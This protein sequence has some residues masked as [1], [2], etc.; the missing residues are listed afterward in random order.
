ML[1]YYQNGYK[2]TK[3]DVWTFWNAVFY[4]G[5]IFTTI[6]K[7]CAIY[8]YEV[9]TE[10]PRSEFNQWPTTPHRPLLLCGGGVSLGANSWDSIFARA[11]KSVASVKSQTIINLQSAT[12]DWPQRHDRTIFIGGGLFIIE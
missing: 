12:R 5:T 2:N 3:G 10:G 6:G 7:L 9:I 8:N 11:G 4:C 1:K